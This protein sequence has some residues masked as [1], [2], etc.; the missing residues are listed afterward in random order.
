MD[1]GDGVV[2]AAQRT[3]CENRTKEWPDLALFMYSLVT[4][5]TTVDPPD[6]RGHQGGNG[7]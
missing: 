3:M 1:H 6:L 5:H 4:E 7:R 2:V